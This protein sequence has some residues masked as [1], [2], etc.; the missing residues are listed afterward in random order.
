MSALDARVDGHSAQ[1]I[2]RSTEAQHI[3]AA[4]GCDDRTF[5][6]SN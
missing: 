3:I 1:I 2:D 6:S 5:A 4:A